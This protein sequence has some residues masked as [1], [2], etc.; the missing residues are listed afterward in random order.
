MQVPFMYPISM[1]NDLVKQVLLG[2]AQES[3]GRQLMSIR[4]MPAPPCA[5]AAPQS[6]PVSGL[7]S[8]SPRQQHVAQTCVQGHWSCPSTAN[9]RTLKI[10]FS[11]QLCHPW[12]T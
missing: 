1:K 2:G 5:T 9:I 3:Y 11:L 7:F 12:Q 8:L 6:P 10:F 4:V